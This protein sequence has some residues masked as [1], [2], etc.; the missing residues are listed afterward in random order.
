VRVTPAGTAVLSLVVDCGAK[1]GDLLMP[2]V[3]TGDEARAIASRLK[4]G[5]VVRI[6][7]SLRATQSRMRSVMT[8]L[9]VEVVAEEIK[10]ADEALSASIGKNN[11][12]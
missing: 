10:L 1:A 6:R 4:N 5:I 11:N 12:G 9:G 2:V 7:G 3:M 8:G